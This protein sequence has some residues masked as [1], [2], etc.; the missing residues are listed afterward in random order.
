MHFA[1]LTLEG[2][3]PQIMP[4]TNFHHKIE[5]LNFSFFFKI[6]Q[7]PFNRIFQINFCVRVPLN[8]TKNHFHKKKTRKTDFDIFV[9]KW[10]NIPLMH[11][12]SL[13]LEDAHP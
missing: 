5:K 4:T 6:I 13:T 10:Y 12:A 3:H 11:F 8:N 7:Y 9:I 2:A 1:S